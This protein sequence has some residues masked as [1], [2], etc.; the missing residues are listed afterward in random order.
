M[1]QKGILLFVIMI[2]LIIILKSINVYI[3]E[4]TGKEVTGLRK[5]GP[6]KENG[7]MHLQF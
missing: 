7:S 4:V 3:N 6:S 5:Y 2:A 1:L